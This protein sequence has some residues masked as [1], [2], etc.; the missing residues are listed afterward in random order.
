MAA[1]SGFLAEHGG[2]IVDAQQHTD[3]A[4]QAFF[5]RLE[6]DP[7]A[8]DLA[9]EEILTALA[10][11]VERFALQVRLRFSDQLHAMG[12]MVSHEEH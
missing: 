8:M 9:P 7:S 10:P 12:I 6:F 3:P 11:V 4:E 2:N 1:L 5:M